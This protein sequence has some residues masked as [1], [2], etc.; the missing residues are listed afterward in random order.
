M[1][2][3]RED[4]ITVFEVLCCAL[5]NDDVFDGF[6]DWLG[7]FPTCC[8]NVWLAS[9]SGGCAKSDELEERMVVQMQNESLTD[10]TVYLLLDS[11]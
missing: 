6:W 3:S 5:F 10:C 9:R 11:T 2:Q 1:I 4:D 7:L 8:F